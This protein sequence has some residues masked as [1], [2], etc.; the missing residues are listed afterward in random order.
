MSDEEVI[1]KFMDLAADAV[2]RQRAEEICET[3]WKLE[4]LDDIKTLTGLLAPADPV[5]G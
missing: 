3:L 4:R 1:G 2:P 5:R